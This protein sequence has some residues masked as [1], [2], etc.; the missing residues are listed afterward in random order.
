M[1]HYRSYRRLSFSNIK[2][3]ILKTCLYCNDETKKVI[4]EKTKVVGFTKVNIPNP[5][6]PV[7][8]YN[9]L[10]LEDE[11]GNRM[12]KKTI[13]DYKIGDVYEDTPDSS[14]SAVSAVKIKYDIYEADH[15]LYEFVSEYLNYKLNGNINFE[16]GDP[17]IEI[18]RSSAEYDLIFLSGSRGRWR[19]PEKPAGICLPRQ[20]CRGFRISRSRLESRSL[21]R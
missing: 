19:C 15:R 2:S 20:R 16:W 21:W 5:L 3:V 14:E 7:T 11:Y 9:V 1:H 6:H 12:P 10:I 13:K 8:P 4:G 17:F 18:M